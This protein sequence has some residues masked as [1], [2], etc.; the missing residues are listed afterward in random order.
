MNIQ[1]LTMAKTGTKVK[2]QI[3]INILHC[4]VDCKMVLQA[5]ELASSGIILVILSL[6]MQLF[7]SKAF[8]FWHLNGSGQDLKI[9][10]KK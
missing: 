6:K 7:T 4:S 3:L 1:V 5:Q 8:K 2:N 10:L 9:L